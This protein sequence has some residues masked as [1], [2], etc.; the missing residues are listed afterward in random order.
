MGWIED[1]ACDQFFNA[2]RSLALT[3]KPSGR[4]VFANEHWVQKMGLSRNDPVGKTEAEL[5]IWH[6]P[7]DLQSVMEML[8][9]N[10]AVK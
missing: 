3:D 6:Q 4:I 10:G 5:G 1:I 2:S 7:G 8:C 9:A